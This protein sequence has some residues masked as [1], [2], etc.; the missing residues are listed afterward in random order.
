MQCSQIEKLLHKGYRR[1]AGAIKAKANPLLPPMDIALAK[2][3][4]PLAMLHWCAVA[5]L[6]LTLTPRAQALPSFA[7]QTG[8][9]CVACHAGGQF[10]ELTPYGRLFKLTGYT[11]GTRSN[12]LAAMIIGDR[13]KTANNADGA[14]GQLS[15]KDEKFIADFASVF[16]AG[17]VTEN[18]GGFAQ[19]TY[20]VHDRQDAQGNWVGYAH[21]DNLDLRYADR[22]VDAKHDFIWGITVNNNP[23]VQDVWNS[24]PAWGY[25]YLATTLGAFPG[26]PT[27]T[28]LESQQQLA[29]IGAYA[30]L[31]QSFYAELSSY[32][33]AKGA[34][35]FLSLGSRTGDLNHPL[36]YVSGSNPYMRLAYTHE[37]GAHNVMVGGFAMN[38]KVLPLDGNNFPVFGAST[39]YKDV[40]FDAQYQY[41]LAPH[42][43]TTQMRY[44]HERINDDVASLYAS[45]ATLDSFKLKGSYVYQAKYGAS[46]A[47]TN[48]NGSADAQ[49]YPSGTANFGSNSNIPN[50]RIWTPEIFWQ[51]T[52]NVRLGIQ[53]NYFTR[54][55]GA[56]TNYDGFGRNARD[57]DTVF[58]YAWLAL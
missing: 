19:F 38:A 31:N 42:T 27:T 5:F 36:T 15:A 52:Q 54:F 4:R 18:I 30:Y 24:S 33:T 43:F 58:L 11:A 12:P 13:T 53:Y 3:W 22:T 44:I 16:V 50:T 34:W 39:R 6:C 35:Q 23:T 56:Q 25:P 1:L 40:G 7:R 57:N 26:A 28:F 21:S 48:V 14:G 29:G 17:K 20:N 2:L 51:P 10:P 49:A 47:F 32:Q 9:S 8:Q 55:N 37:W 41:L 45:P 46:L